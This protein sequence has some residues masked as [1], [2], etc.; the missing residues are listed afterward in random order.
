MRT[1]DIITVL[2]DELEKHPMTP[3]LIAGDIN[4]DVNMF[5]TLEEMC[6]QGGWTDVGAQAKAWG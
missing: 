4:G 6:T 3:Q 1:N 5:P 2:R